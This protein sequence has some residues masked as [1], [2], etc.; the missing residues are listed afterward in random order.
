MYFNKR[1]LI[2]KIKEWLI[3]IDILQY[4]IKIHDHTKQSL[5]KYSENNLKELKKKIIISKTKGSGHR[6]MITW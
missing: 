2:E 4:H 1:Y 3:V 6:N 5:G